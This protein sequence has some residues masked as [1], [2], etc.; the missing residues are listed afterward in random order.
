MADSQWILDIAAQMPD[1]AATIAELDELTERLVGASRKSDDFQAALKRVTVDLEAAKTASAQ[2]AAALAQG[3]EQYKLLE[4]EAVRTAK[5]LESANAKGRF[6]PRAARSAHE[7]QTALD[8][9]TGTL[10]NLESASSAATGKQTAL[11]KSL[12][13]LTKLGAH[14]DA[15]N[16][17]LAQRYEKLGAAVSRL[18][19]PLGQ[20]GGQLIGSGKAAHELGVAFGKSNLA[21][22]AFAAA[23][24]V[25][26][27]AVVA[28]SVA[29][30]AGAVAFTRYA[31][32]VADTARNARLAQEAFAAVSDETAVAVTVF[33]QLSQATGLTDDN[34]RALTRKLIDMKVA[35][36]DIPAALKAAATA[37]A[38]LG[39]GGSNVFFD[40]LKKDTTAV[41]KLAKEIDT[42]FGGIV[43]ERLRGIDAQLGR[44]SKTWD[45]LFAGIKIDP[46]LDALGVLV[47]MF[48]KGNP[49]AQAFGLGVEGAINP[50]GPMAMRAAY[51][52]EAFALGFAIQL[53][54]MYIAVKPALKWL[55]EFFGASSDGQGLLDTFA[56]IGEVAA[57]L[58][59]VAGGVLLAAVTAVGA[60]FAVAAGIAAGFVAVIYG[61]VNSVLAVGKILYWLGEIVVEQTVKF[62]TLGYDL[63]MG[64]VSGI[65][66]AVSAVV[67]AVSGAVSSAIGTAKE[68]LGI[69][70]PSK[71][72]AEIGTDTA[73]GFTQGVEAGAPEAQG[74]MAAL[75]GPDSAAA[76]T[77]PTAGGEGA[78]RGRASIDLSGATFVFNGVPGAEGARDMLA[79]MFTR[80][81]EGDADS[82]AG[83]EVPA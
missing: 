73:D 35:A 69:A 20:I 41:A 65:T 15:R 76:G 43:V 12:A 49:L 45:Q 50:I 4:R 51:A 32:S 67:G 29:A 83:A 24:V 71:V 64:L 75:V 81:L 33:D 19:G 60:A 56:K 2:A 38:A 27:A 62:A 36:K 23:A 72:F 18:P 77:Q 55:G 21:M 70:S 11:A 47:G 3:T 74:S 48:E 9:Y 68:L 1:G 82:L 58:A 5:A 14:A 6:D 34:L 52:V 79:E 54:K 25:T 40:D 63:M 53:T 7:A 31:V 57:V 17:A 46:F 8:A 61:A 44:L 16:A 10:K 37:E 39:T 80:L 66:S 13:N 42:K 26:V 22:F 30:V 78:S 28:L 59:V